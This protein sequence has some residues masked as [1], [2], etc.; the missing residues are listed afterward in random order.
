MDPLHWAGTGNAVD[1]LVTWG[2]P[3]DISGIGATVA[4]R[5]RMFQAKVFA[6]RV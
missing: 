2:G 3:H 4:V 1:R 6:C 5:I